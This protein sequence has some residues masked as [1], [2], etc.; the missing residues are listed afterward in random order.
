MNVA[1]YIYRENI[2]QRCIMRIIC[3]LQGCE[4]P[5]PCNIGKNVRFPHGLKGIVIHPNTIIGDEVTIFHQVT[6]GRG[7]MFNIDKRVKESKFD[8]IIFKKGAVL[9]V[10]AKVICN[11]G[12]LIVGENTVIGANAVLTKST[13][14][15]EVWE[16]VLAK[17][18]KKQ[19][20]KII[21]DG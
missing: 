5:P 16:G 18:I 21:Y 12:I 9:C 4:L 11:R 19:I 17:Y 3:K 20:I 6:C 13:G 2:F 10:G 14:D 8:G 1:K 15:D 7:D